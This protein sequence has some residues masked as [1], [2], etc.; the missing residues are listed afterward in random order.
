MMPRTRGK[1]L[2]NTH[3]VNCYV[4]GKTFWIRSLFIGHRKTAFI[5]YACS[6]EYRKHVYSKG[7]VD[8]Y[9]LIRESLT[10]GDVYS[11]EDAEKAHDFLESIGWIE[12]LVADRLEKGGR[13]N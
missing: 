8:L 4:C 2:D 1:K 12:K 9:P 3:H 10:V 5:C 7:L 13:T 6:G 11:V